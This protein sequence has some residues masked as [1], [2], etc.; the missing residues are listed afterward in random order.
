MSALGGRLDHVERSIRERID[1][2][3]HLITPRLEEIY[4]TRIRTHEQL[5]QLSR[6]VESISARQ[7]HLIGAVRDYSFLVQIKRVVGRRFRKMFGS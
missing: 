7:E 2:I 3:E 4:S 6:R 5:E 1:K